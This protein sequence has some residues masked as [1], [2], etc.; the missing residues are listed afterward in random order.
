MKHRGKME[1]GVEIT[2]LAQRTMVR[3]TDDDMI[4]H[5]DLKELAGTDKVTGHF[6]VSFGW[7]RLTAGMIVHEND[8][9]SRCDERCSKHFAWVDQQG[10]ER[11]HGSQVMA[12]E[13]AARV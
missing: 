9:G 3:V 4:E 1:S 2:Q 12:S 10:V 8:C 13:S 6:D 7:L 5:L 11:S